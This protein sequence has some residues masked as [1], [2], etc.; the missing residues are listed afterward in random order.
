M[1]GWINGTGHRRTGIDSHAG[2]GPHVSLSSQ[3]SSIKLL[4]G[5]RQEEQNYRNCETGLQNRSGWP[6]MREDASAWFGGF[7]LMSMRKIAALQMGLF[8]AAVLANAAPKSTLRITVLDSATRALAADNNGVPLNCDQLTFD[9][10][11]R[12]TTNA[13]LLSTLLVKEDNGQTYHISC[14]VESKYSRC[15][16][17]AKG[18]SYDAKRTKHGLEVYYEDDNGK[19]R[20]QLYSLVDT[21]GK[22]APVAAAAVSVKPVPP[23]AGT[24]QGLPVPAPAPAAVAPQ[25]ASPEKVSEK[26]KC[27]FTSTP[28]G[29]EITVDGKYLGSTPSEIPLSAGMHVV[30]FSMP[31]FAQW[32]RDLT[33]LPGSELTVGA[34]LQREQP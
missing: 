9:A 24:Q 25:Q 28:A 32:K 34:I 6:R 8:L 2:H 23:G 17:L 18:E 7:G 29:A 13:P 5:T 21:N 14:T 1:S 26:A 4:C 20:K 33:V 16:P 30:V 11:C 12:S 3:N 10:Y 22:S 19:T 31:G 27:S 15:V